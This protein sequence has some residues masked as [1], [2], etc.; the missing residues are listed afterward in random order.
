VV[1]ASIAGVVMLVKRPKDANPVSFDEWPDVPR[2]PILN[3][4]PQYRIA[5]RNMTDMQYRRLGRSGLK[6]SLLSFGS[7]VT[8]A[9]ADQ[10]ETGKQAAEC[11]H[12]AKEAGVNFFD[13]AESYAAASP[14][15]SWVRPFANWAGSVTSTW[16]PPSSSGTA[17]ISQHAQH[18]EP[19]VP[20]QAIDGSLERFGLDFVDLVFCHRPDAE[21][22]IEE[23]VWAMSDMITKA[24]RSTGAPRSGAPMRSARPTT[25]PIATTCT[26]R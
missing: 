24:R 16:S 1:A 3:S 23:T 21:T 4:P 20:L 7:W 15:A 9:N 11:L 25:S 17:Q 12:A 13:N 8:F 19:Q 22:P 14:S 5:R 26:S 6:V 10:I 18:P 2:N